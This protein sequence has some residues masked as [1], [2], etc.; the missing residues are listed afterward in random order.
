V[1]G[2]R[3]RVGEDGELVSGQR[4]V[5]E[6]VDDDEAKVLHRILETVRL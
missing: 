6:D 4:P 1:L 2:N 5:R 3:L